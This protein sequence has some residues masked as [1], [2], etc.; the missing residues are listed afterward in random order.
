[1]K[2]K[3][4]LLWIALLLTG[5]FASCNDDGAVGLDLLPNPDGIGVF[6]LDTFSI[7][8][9][10]VTEDSLEVQQPPILAL[11]EVS[12]PVF[13]LSKVGLTYQ[14]LLTNENI[15]LGSMCRLILWCWP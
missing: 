12:D 7:R 6:K 13:G 11:G 10:T 2:L 15:N 5:L 3:Y 14:V 1:M 9:Y 4:D 8:T